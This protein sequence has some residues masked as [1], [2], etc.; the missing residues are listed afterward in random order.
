MNRSERVIKL[1]NFTNDTVLFL[2][3]LTQYPK[4]QVPKIL[5]V[6][7]ENGNTIVHVMFTLTEY[8]EL[9]NYI[10]NNR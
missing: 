9:Q 5:L 3:F 7:M 2:D 4:N 1:E 6:K 10:K 8:K